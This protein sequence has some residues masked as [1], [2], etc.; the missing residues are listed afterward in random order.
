[1]EMDTADAVAAAATHPTVV[2]CSA[3]DQVAQPSVQSTATAHTFLPRGKKEITLEARAAESKKRAARRVVAKQ[4]EEDRKAAEEKV[5]QTEMLQAVHARATVEALA[6]QAAFHVIA[7][8]KSEVVTQFAAGQ[9]GSTASSVS[10]AV[11]WQRPASPALS[12]TREP[13]SQSAA[14]SCLGVLAA[15]TADGGVFQPV[16]DLSRMP[17]AGDTLSGHSKAPR[18]RAADDLPDAA[19]LFGQM[20]TQPMVDEVLC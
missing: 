19:D 8:L 18:A 6:K 12:S 1:M 3:V 16:I 10:S 7:M 5:R 15:S 14:P 9:F 20:P 11:G 4:K 13:P 2:E 17:V